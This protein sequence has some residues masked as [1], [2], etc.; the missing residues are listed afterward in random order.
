MDRKLIVLFI[1]TIFISCNCEKQSTTPDDEKLLPVAHAGEDQVSLVGSYG[2]LNALQS[3]GNGQAITKY[4]W[5]QYWNNPET[6][7]FRDY[8]ASQKVGFTKEGTYR[9]I[10]RVQTEAGISL[11]DTLKIEVGPREN[12]VFEDPNLEVHLHWMFKK[13]NEPLT[14]DDYLN[15]DTLDTGYFSTYDIFSIK[16][17]EVCENLTYLHMHSEQVSDLEPLSNLIKLVT[18]DFSENDS[19]KSLEPLIKL[20]NLEYVDLRCNCIIDIEPIRNLINVKRLELND[21]IFINEISA[22]ECLKDLEYL[23]FGPAMIDDINP[24]KNLTRLERLLLVSCNIKNISPVENLTNLDVLYLNWNQIEDISCLFKLKK[25]VRLYLDGNRVKDISVLEGLTGLN[26]VI[27]C[28]N[29][30][31][32]IKPLVDNIGINQGDLVDVSGNPLNE[33]SRKEYI[34]ILRNRGVHVIG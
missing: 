20:K 22:V 10:L 6:V 19:I 9:F 27:L 34:P 14:E 2:I 25:L 1:A 28:D 33:V 29:L 8:E 3:Q 4:I 13:Q 26:F 11:P 18:I 5:S 12:P 24:V 32:D 31:E 23:Y 16:G 15:I 7:R 21:N 30:I 17:I